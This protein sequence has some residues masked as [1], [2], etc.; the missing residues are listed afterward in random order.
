MVKLY[1]VVFRKYINSLRNCVSSETAGNP[2]CEYLDTP[3]S[4]LIVEED[5]LDALR[6]YGEGLKTVEFVGML[7][8]PREARD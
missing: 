8:E 2:Y 3:D 4:C 6:K 1:K 7:H 5:D